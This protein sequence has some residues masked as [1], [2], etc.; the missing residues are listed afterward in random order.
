MFLQRHEVV[1]Q[2][3]KAVAELAKPHSRKKNQLFNGTNNVK[4]FTYHSRSWID[5]GSKKLLSNQ[6]DSQLYHLKVTGARKDQRPRARIAPEI[7]F[8]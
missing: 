3:G 5:E 4:N 7:V 8:R 2:L 6:F 1:V